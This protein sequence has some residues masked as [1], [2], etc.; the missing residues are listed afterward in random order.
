MKKQATVFL[1]LFIATL[2]LTSCRKDFEFETLN[3]KLAFS[4]DTI[5]FAP[6]FNQTTSTT[7]RLKVY[8]KSN[9][10]VSIPKVY[11]S[12][13][14]NS[15]YD[16][17]LN[18]TVAK[19]FT[20]VQL[21]AKDSLVIFIS[22]FV[23]D[24]PKNEFLY[25]DQINFS[26]TTNNQTV[27]L[28][29]LAKDAVLLFPQKDADGNIQ[30][31]TI[32]DNQ[33]V[34]GFLLSADQL[35]LT[36]KKPYVIYGFAVVPE[37]K[38]LVI[39]P[40]AKL[41]FHTNSGI[42]AQAK[43]TIEANATKSK[44][45]IMQS[46]RLQKAYQYTPGLWSGIWLTS[47]AKALFNHTVIKQAY[48]SIY[49]QNSSDLKLDNVEIY[50]SEAYGIYASKS[51]IHAQ[52][53]VIGTASKACLSLNDGGEYQFTHATFAN[54]AQRPDQLAIAIQSDTHSDNTSYLFQNCLIYS[55][56]RTSLYIAPE[57]L[58]RENILLKC[59]VIKDYLANQNTY[60]NT[61]K[62]V[63]NTILYS[64]TDGRVSFVNPTKN[65]LQLTSQSTPFLGKAN[66]EIAKIVPY[67]ILG[68]SRL[69]SPDYGA[70][71][72]VSFNEE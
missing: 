60:S 31:I 72:H 1:L 44:P 15:Y 37:N 47:D 8:N 71:Q 26:G 69:I 41:Y 62:F 27:E 43:S 35:I 46:S 30:Q 48:T 14:E 3:D 52:N 9:K 55:I 63:Q 10:N 67:D 2:F 36:N 11:L 66:V 70:Y 61:T 42:I 39:Q 21:L 25:T 58:E 6:V 13:G 7:Y 38:T 19:S 51:K 23:K 5:F 17:L 18:G 45:I 56:S 68:N 50:D 20:N 34:N 28:V 4:R 65:Q 32:N 16:L 49:A 53:I 33:K 57:T 22:A 12:K 54:F 29:T 64:A 59:N 40:G 24:T